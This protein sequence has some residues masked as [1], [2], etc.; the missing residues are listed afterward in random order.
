MH[1][2]TCY[3]SWYSMIIIYLFKPWIVILFPVALGLLKKQNASPLLNFR[4]LQPEAAHIQ[5]FIDALSSTVQCHGY[6]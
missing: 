3:A 1:R 2:V 4:R 5:M 6:R